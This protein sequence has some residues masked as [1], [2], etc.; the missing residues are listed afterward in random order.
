MDTTIKTLCPVCKTEEMRGHGGSFGG[1][2]SCWKKK[3]PECNLVLLIVPMS[4]NYEYSILAET[5]DE[6]E[7]K[8]EKRRKIEELEKQA[9]D[10]RRELRM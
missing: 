10:L 8:F 4:E 2:I 9:D 6:I 7:A 5:K 1:R 3:C